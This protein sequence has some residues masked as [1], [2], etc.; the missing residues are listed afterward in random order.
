MS[1]VYYHFDFRSAA[2]R[3]CL[4]DRVG[5]ERKQNCELS[6]GAR[7][8]RRKF[9][10]AMSNASQ[11]GN[12]SLPWPN[13]PPPADLIT[14]ILLCLQLKLA[15]CCQSRQTPTK[16]NKSTVG[17]PSFP[18]PSNPR[19]AP[20]NQTKKTIS[21][22]LLLRVGDKSNGCRSLVVFCAS[23]FAGQLVVVAAAAAAF[24]PMGERPFDRVN[25]Q[26]RA[27]RRMFFCPSSPAPCCCCC[28][29]VEN[30]KRGNKIRV[31][32]NRIC[33]TRGRDLPPR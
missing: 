32:I 29:F 23:H 11:K 31:C 5:V 1:D 3:V 19:I 12:T 24:V 10:T 2:R 28:S 25:K 15:N 21:T 16:A 9:S 4:V 22:L 26:A 30:I 27:A 18:P 33:L 6:C 14:R 13:P 8:S 20:S 17:R 7:S